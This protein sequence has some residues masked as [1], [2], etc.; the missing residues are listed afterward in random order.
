PAWDSSYYPLMMTQNVP[1]KEYLKAKWWLFVIVTAVSMVLAVFYV[2][3]TSWTFYFTIF[4]A[5]L[6][7]LGVNSYLTLLAGAYN[8]KP[9][10]LNSASKGFTAGQNNF[11]IKILIIIIP[12]MLVPMAVFGIVKYFAGMSAA[13][14][15]LGILGL[16]GFLLRDKIFDQIVKIYR[17]E[18]YS[19]LA[20]FKKVD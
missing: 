13:V 6:Y 8:K 11:N 16:I 20:A 14:I 17:S 1:Y 4:A 15:S 10:D 2:F 7:N 9:I 3:F 19:T 12:Q 5:G 18:K